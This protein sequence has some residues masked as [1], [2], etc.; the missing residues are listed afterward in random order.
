MVCFVVVTRLASPELETEP[1]LRRLGVCDARAAGPD[2]VLYDG[3]SR[4][5][6]RMQMPSVPVT[7]TEVRSEL[8]RLWQRGELDSIPRGVRRSVW[9]LIK[10]KRL[11]TVK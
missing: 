3:D 2:R 1:V 11:Y 9:Q 8:V 6:D 7:A 4:W 5:V 10:E